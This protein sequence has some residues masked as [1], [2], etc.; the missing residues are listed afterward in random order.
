[1]SLQ[2]VNRF[3]LAAF[4][5]H[6][7]PLLVNIV[8]S[9]TQLV[10]EDEAD[11]T[12]RRDLFGT[13]HRTGAMFLQNLA[14]D[15]LLWLAQILGPVLCTQH[16]TQALLWQLQQCFVLTPHMMKMEKYS[17]RPAM[18][19]LQCLVN[20]AILFGEALLMDHYLPRLLEMVRR[21]SYLMF[22]Y[23]AWYVLREDGRKGRVTELKY[24]RVVGYFE[25]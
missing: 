24:E 15:A 21:S 6:F 1:M 16:L 5:D 12:V 9:P 18:P 23:C 20:M 19:A 10:D 8:T 4:L 17:S 2:V 13:K 11:E 22:L 7:V 14:A 25:V 3:G